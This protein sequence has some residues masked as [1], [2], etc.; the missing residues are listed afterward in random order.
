MTNMVD[1]IGATK[2]TYNAAGQLLTED[3]PF[4]SDTVANTY[5]N[6]L[7]VGLSLQQPTG[8]WTNGFGYDSTKRLT[9]V[10]SPAG[11]FDYFYEPTLFTHH[12]SLVTLPNTSYITNAFDGNARLIATYLEN[13]GNTVL[14][15]YTYIY[16][17][18]NQRTNLTRAD[19]STVG[20]KYD[21]IGQIKVAD[22]S[23][24]TEDRGYLYDAA[25]NLA[26]RTNNG[27]TSTFPV[28]LKNQLTAEPGGDSDVYDANGNLTQRNTGSGTNVYN[29]YQYTYDDENRLVSMLH[30][31]GDVSGWWKTD[32]VYDGLGRLR[33]R[34]EYA[35]YAEG[36]LY[37]NAF[38]SYIYDGWRVI[39]ER[40]Y[41]NN[42]P[43]VSYTRGN[44]LSGSME[45][46]GG[47]GGLLARSSGYSGG[48]FTTHSYYFA[49][50]N[51]TY[52]LNSS[53][54]MVAKYRY[55]PFGN[56]IS[57]SGTLAA[58]NLYRF[59][60]KEIHA[61][62]GMYYYGYRFYDPN[63][64]RWINRDPLGE[65]GFEKQRDTR[66]GSVWR[67]TEFAELSEGS[68]LYILVHNS[69]IAK[70]DPF[71]CDTWYCACVVS[72][73]PSST[74]S[75]GPFKIPGAGC[76]INCVCN[77]VGTKEV[78]LTHGGNND[79]ILCAIAFG[80]TQGQPIGIIGPWPVGGDLD[81]RRK[82]Q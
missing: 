18:A 10:T 11:E 76:Q 58:D 61:N 43:S 23:V 74:C 20:Y 47:I 4:A 21:P 51:V 64:Q 59:S 60:S 75:V 50:G 8:S 3:G 14:D 40:S 27:S 48:N 46:A 42:S 56:T 53:Q 28:D 13:S 62:S 36:W 9:R 22:S 69:P 68:N 5:A 17:P 29:V 72:G 6:R 16:N 52:M 38:V 2:Y 26:R 63:L 30:D 78:V 33:K 34:T 39:Q 73:D 67:F 25:W 82:K 55:D 19:A 80:L 15:S 77:N 81:K 32:F 24:N 12:P 44:D 66:F 65:T 1:G 79:P 37:T 41:N 71:G 49:D 45:G 54:A 57:S 31:Y 70:I 7:R 35:Y